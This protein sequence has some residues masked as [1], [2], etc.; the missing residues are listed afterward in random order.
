MLRLLGVSAICAAARFRV[1]QPS[2]GALRC[3]DLSAPV[4]VNP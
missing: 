2:E 3:G 1:S 4:T